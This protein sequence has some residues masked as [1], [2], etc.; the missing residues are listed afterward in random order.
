MIYIK[1]VYIIQNF[2]IENKH[3]NFT[4]KIFQIILM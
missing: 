1:K 4:I 3:N 2:N